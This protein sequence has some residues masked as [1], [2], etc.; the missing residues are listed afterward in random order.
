MRINFAGPWR[1]VGGTSWWRAVRIESIF[2]AA[3]VQASQGRT[4]H[5]VAP[6]GSIS[7]LKGPH[8]G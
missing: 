1:C 6:I 7:Y 8:V 4:G 5:L 2:D 3:A